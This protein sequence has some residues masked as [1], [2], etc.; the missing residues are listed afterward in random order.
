[1]SQIVIGLTDEQL[2]RVDALAARRGSSREAIALEGLALAL[3]QGEP[4]PDRPKPV[5]APKTHAGTHK[6]E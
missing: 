5:A 3:A 6:E 4:K 1:M 2:Q